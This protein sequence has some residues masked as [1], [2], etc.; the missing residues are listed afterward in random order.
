LHAYI[1]LLSES[2]K[3][4]FGETL[5]EQ[6][7]KTVSRRRFLRI[8]GGAVAAAAVVGA[9][10]GAY[11]YAAPKPAA[12]VTELSALIQKGGM[13]PPAEIAL[14][15]FEEKSGIKIAMT[16]IPWEAQ[17]EKTMAEFAAKSTTYDIIPV[18]DRWRGGM[19][20][21]VE[22]LRPYVEKYGPNPDE[23]PKGI[24]RTCFWKNKLVGL[25]FRNGIESI[26][27]YRK[28]LY[29][30]FGLKVA[31]TLEEY[32]E[33][34]R[35]L[36]RDNM[37][38][39]S[40]MFAGD[41]VTFMEFSDWM[42]NL[43]GRWVTEEEDAV[44]PF[45]PHGY[46]AIE[47]LS[48]FK[49]MLEKKYC[50]PGV[51]TYGIIDVLQAYQTGV[52]AQA[53]MYSPRVLLVEDPTKSQAAGKT[54]YSIKL[55]N[56]PSRIMAGPRANFLSG[57]TFS[58]NLWISPERKEAAFQAIKYMVSKEAQLAA[59]L[60]AANGPTRKDVLEDPEWQKVYPAYK[61]LIEG[62]EQGKSGSP[63]TPAFAEISKIVSEET[64]LAL[65]G[66]K[67]V[68]EAVKAMWKRNEEVMKASA[69]K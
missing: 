64:G 19:A 1:N 8:G 13:G 52:V 32:E 9:A 28:D 37:Y 36:T 51:L 3:S 22:D 66:K 63:A 46:K 41:P 14:K 29:E 49:R 15:M 43:G 31:N 55:P 16:P 47:I 44:A 68:E 25:P 38:G 4:F 57:W 34:S 26:L 21:Y 58:V 53:N 45:D 50:P 67:T 10:Y 20:R 17:F 69:T 23:F 61:V 56:A 6:E 59:A 24:W 7:N 18:L 54:G 40:F 12:K 33:N 27:Y 62:Y 39:S 35:V 2:L 30:K 48:F 42:Y 65:I 5:T 60:K 11:Q